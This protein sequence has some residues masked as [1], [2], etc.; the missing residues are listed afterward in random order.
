MLLSSSVLLSACA[1][2]KPIDSVAA[3]EVPRGLLTCQ[4]SPP[5][6]EFKSQKDVA[7][8]IVDLW[9]AGQDCRQKLGAIRS[10]VAI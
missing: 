10:Y 6:P 9:E 5:V 2:S 3:L 8:Y 7:G 4:P 1:S